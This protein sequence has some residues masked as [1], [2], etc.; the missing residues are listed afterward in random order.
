M[1][2]ATE[3]QRRAGHPPQIF[4]DTLMNSGETDCFSLHLLEADA[5][6]PQKVTVT[7]AANATT[8]AVSADVRPEAPVCVST[9]GASTQS[10]ATGPD[11]TPPPFT[12]R[13]SRLPI[14]C[15]SPT[16]DTTLRVFANHG[17]VALGAD[18]AVHTPPGTTLAANCTP[19]TS[20]PSQ[21]PPAS[22]AKVRLVP[23]G[24]TPACA[25][26]VSRLRQRCCRTVV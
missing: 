22:H 13:P 15:C 10:S 21:S 19:A 3:N 7:V 25:Q 6:A 20:A 12:D 14:S 1:R 16:P 18:G 17:N 24:P 2:T 4:V 26:R 23:S 11:G 5:K 9:D 8:S